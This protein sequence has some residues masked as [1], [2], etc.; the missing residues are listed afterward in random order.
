[1]PS[2][3]MRP[4]RPTNVSG[5]GMNYLPHASL[6]SQ[7]RK[8]I[9]HGRALHCLLDQPGDVGSD[10]SQAAHQCLHVRALGAERRDVLDDLGHMFRCRLR[11]TQD[12]PMLPAHGYPIT[13]TRYCIARGGT[14]KW[15]A[16][17]SLLTGAMPVQTSWK[18]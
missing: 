2:S 11:L 12:L 6:T 13:M 14:A 5:S 16:T 18:Q 4:T 3:N 10:S 1:M 15:T 8:E 7:D 9:A 17:S